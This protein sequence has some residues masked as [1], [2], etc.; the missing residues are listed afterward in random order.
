MIAA[1]LEVR[2]EQWLFIFASVAG[3]WALFLDPTRDMPY[4]GDDPSEAADPWGNL[5]K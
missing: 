3:V 4:T 5:D 2:L 1:L